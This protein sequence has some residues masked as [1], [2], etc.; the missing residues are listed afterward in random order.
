MDFLAVS[1]F[2]V[3]PG[4]SRE[5]QEWVRA[6]AVALSA[7]SPEGIELIGIYASMFSSEKQAGHYRTIWRLDSY[8]AMDRFAAAIPGNPELA[9]LL[10]ELDSFSDNRLGAGS[11]NELLKSVADTTIWGDFQDEE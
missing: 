9:R 5:L 10:D 1:G 7:N 8:R 11:S 3:K 4:K 2:D 6:N